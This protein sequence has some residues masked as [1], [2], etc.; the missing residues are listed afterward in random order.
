MRYGAKANASPPMN[1][2]PSSE[3]NSRQSRN[4]ARP[5]SGKDHSSATL[6]ASTGLPVIQMIGEV[7]GVRPTRLSVN[8]ATP[9]AGKKAGAFHHADE[10]GMVLAFHS[11]I[12]AFR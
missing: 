9:G 1:D 8:A 6:W 12:Q 3:L 2:A 4:A 11:R 5:A 10:N 7:I